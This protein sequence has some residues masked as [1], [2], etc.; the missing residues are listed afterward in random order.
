MRRGSKVNDSAR[1]AIFPFPTEKRSV[2]KIERRTH[3]EGWRSRKGGGREFRKVSRRFRRERVPGNIDL[4]SCA[5]MARIRYADRHRNPQIC[6]VHRE[7]SAES[8]LMVIIIL[9][10]RSVF[11]CPPHVPCIAFIGARSVAEIE[12][13]KSREGR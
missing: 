12:I 7:M 10:S 2:R 11:A 4:S 5:M 8:R 6:F 13:L 3:G 1:S 9:I